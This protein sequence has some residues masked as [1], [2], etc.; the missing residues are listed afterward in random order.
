MD[1]CQIINNK[2]SA[3]QDGEV[4][5]AEKAAVETHLRTCEACRRKHEALLLTY[6]ILRSL[7]EIEP[8]PE[9]F[10]QIV[11]RATRVQEP[12]W[13]R[14]LGSAL[15]SLPASAAMAILAVAGLLIGAFMA[16]FLTERQFHPSRAFSAFHSDQALVL[17]SVQVFDATPP[18]SFAEGYLKLTAYN[19]EKGH[20]K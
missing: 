6:Q 19:P 12:F 4:T 9:L 18:G 17:A 16:N 1:S 11:K 20:E 10:R 7:P 8:A 13:V 14:V 5:K 3:Y 15:R 2:L